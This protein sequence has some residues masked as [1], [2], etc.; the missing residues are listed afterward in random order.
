MNTFFQ[1]AMAIA[2]LIFGAPSIAGGGEENQNVGAGISLVEHRNDAYVCPMEHGGEAHKPGFCRECGMELVNKM[3]Q[4]RVAVLIFNEVEDIDFAGP[5]EVFGQSGA[6]FFTVAADTQMVRSVAGLKIQPDFDFQHAP[7]ADIVL[8]PGGNVSS[9][10]SNPKLLDWIRQRSEDSRAVLSICTGAFI[11]AKAG[12]LDGIS[13]TTIASAIPMLAAAAPKTQV[14][15]DRRYVDN[16]KIITTGGLSA[17]IDGALHVIDREF[18]RMRAVGVARDLEYEWR[19][20]GVSEF[21]TLAHLQLPGVTSIFPVEASWRKL[22][23]HGDAQQWKVLGH[24]E[25]AMNAEEFLSASSKLLAD[26]G[27][28]SRDSGDSRRSYSKRVEGQ[29]WLFS[30]AIA[31]KVEPNVFHVS[32]AVEKSVAAN[33]QR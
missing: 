8:I 14:V 19:I 17:G 25:I 26:D 31:E 30:L 2:M 10:I 4:L 23:E 3:D 29:D 9:V 1:T 32:M 21:G 15:R 18:G 13:S 12:L 7:A 24:L 27:W 6:S 16:G 33:A 11:L 28:S 5:M 22:E 20:D